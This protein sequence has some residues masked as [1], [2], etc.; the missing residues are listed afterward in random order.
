M[1]MLAVVEVRGTSDDFRCNCVL[2]SFIAGIGL[3]GHVV[4]KCRKDAV[5]KQEGALQRCSVRS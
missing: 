1:T 4:K 5:T 2:K 3:L